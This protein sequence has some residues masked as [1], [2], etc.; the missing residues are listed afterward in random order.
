M[1]N[2][3]VG[4]YLEGSLA[5]GGFD[6]DSDIDFVAVTKEPVTEDRF[7]ALQAMHDRIAR[8]DSWWAIQLE[9]S[10]LSRHAFRRHDPEQIRH[11]S[12]ER[13]AGERLKM[14]DHDEAWN[15]HRYIL[16]ESGITLVGP[17]P[18]TLIDPVSAEDLR[19]SMLPLLRGW[20]THLLHNP[21][22]M[23]QRGYQSYVVLSLCRILYTLTFGKVASKPQAVGW[24]TENLDAQWKRLIERAWEGRSTPGITA[25][26]EDIRQTQQMI[27]FTISFSKQDQKPDHIL[28]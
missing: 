13:G 18:K 14:A 2:N 19:K 23:E 28:W 7:L 9:G 4:M 5:H 1:Q 25:E 17:P 8:L 11:P 3:L 15:I 21:Q 27:L 6:H 24:A 26:T 10:Y 20:A 22:A 16:R 12:I